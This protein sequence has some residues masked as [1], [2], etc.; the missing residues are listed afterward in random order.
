MRTPEGGPALPS[1]P[2]VIST[3]RPGRTITLEVGNGPTSVIGDESRLRQVLANLLVNALIHTPTGTAIRV[4]LAVPRPD[5]RVPT[6][7]SGSG[8]GCTAADVVGLEVTDAGRGM[9]QAQASHDLRP[10]LPRRQRPHQ[11]Y[12]RVRPRPVHRSVHRRRPRRANRG[13]HRPRGRRHLPR[14]ATSTAVRG[15]RLAVPGRGMVAACIRGPTQ[16]GRVELDGGVSAGRHRWLR[17][18]RL[19][20]PRPSPGWRR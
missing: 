19:R 14:R 12:R 5:H 10:L 15:S 11:G 13:L 2:E 9:T 16:R 1:R 6:A 4:A 18:R 3:F 7:V 8:S 20:R 17:R